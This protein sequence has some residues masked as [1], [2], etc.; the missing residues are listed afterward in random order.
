MRKDKLDKI[1]ADS[2]NLSHK[3]LK[4]F[5]RQDHIEENAQEIGDKIV[6]AVTKNS[7]KTFF[8]LIF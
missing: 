8:S 5:P 7:F 2:R 1:K 3:S 6:G 4:K